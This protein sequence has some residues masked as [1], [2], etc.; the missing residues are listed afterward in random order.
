MRGFD[1]RD[2]TR[3]SSKLAL[4]VIDSR[5]RNCIAVSGPLELVHF[6]KLTINNYSVEKVQITL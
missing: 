2:V 6:P 5:E 1:K 3:K 4:R